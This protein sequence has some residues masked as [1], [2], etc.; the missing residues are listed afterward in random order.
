M[1][2]LRDVDTVKNHSQCRTQDFFSIKV[3]F[4]VLRCLL[5]QHS[6][7]RVDSGHINFDYLPL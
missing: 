7:F 4:S 2:F 5:T 1:Q 3:V 6:N